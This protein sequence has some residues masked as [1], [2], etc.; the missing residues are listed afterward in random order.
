MAGVGA[1]FW[2]VLAVGF[3]INGGGPALL[4]QGL[5]PAAAGLAALL[6]V[7]ARQLL[8]WRAAHR[9]RRHGTHPGTHCAAHHNAHHR[10]H[11]TA[12]QAPPGT[13]RATYARDRTATACCA[14]LAPLEAA[15]RAGGHPLR[16]VG[17]GVVQAD[18][19]IDAQALQGS[20]LQP[21]V[22]VHE[23]WHSRD[24]QGDDEPVARLRC[25]VCGSQLWVLH[26]Q[27]AGVAPVFTPAGRA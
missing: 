10:A 21:R 3:R 14:H 11:H 26:P 13:D 4:Q 20:P 23:A 2:V 25:T 16:W 17:P 18:C 15:L 22:V 12:P 6:L 27:V 8:R 9:A 5:W 24:R 7:G 19:G 1:G